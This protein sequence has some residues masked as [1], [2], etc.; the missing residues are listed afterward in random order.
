VTD[1]IDLRQEEDDGGDESPSTFAQIKVMEL[2]EM[3]RMWIIY[4]E[5][6]R[7]Q[8]ITINCS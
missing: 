1:D 7:V 8:Y 3:P 6:G 4:D 5:H 2:A